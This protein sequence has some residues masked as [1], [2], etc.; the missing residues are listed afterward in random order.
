ML[1]VQE[2][3]GGY[4]R[5][6]FS[7]TKDKW[8]YVEIDP[9]DFVLQDGPNDPKDANGQLDRDKIKFIGLI[10]FDQ[11]LIQM[12]AGAPNPIA[13]MLQI[14]GGART[15]YLDDVTL[16]GKGLPQAEATPEVYDIDLFQR[17]QAEWASVGGATLERME[18]KDA[19]DNALRVTYQQAPGRLMGLIKPLQRGALTGKKQ[20]AFQ[21][22]SMKRT[23]FLVQL[24]EAGGGKYNASMEVPGNAAPTPITLNFADFK[25]SD[26]S[27]DDN[28]QLDLDQVRQLLVVDIS[29]VMG[30]A[31]PMVAPGMPGE[32]PGNENTLWLN[33]LRAK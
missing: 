33:A 6:V 32:L 9:T 21:A 17:P 8:Q 28:N 12:L 14:Q 18:A 27:N 2:D 20:L 15:F 13:Q 19:K 7:V 1:A 16:S 5:A 26:D 25:T 4:F 10:D 23:T 30:G 31:P 3:G 29:G 11:V 24:E 22:A